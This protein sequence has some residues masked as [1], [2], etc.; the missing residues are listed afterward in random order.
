MTDAEKHLWKHIRKLQLGSFRFVRQFSIGNF[1]LDFYCPKKRLAIEIDGGQHN[2]QKKKLYDRKKDKIL[3]E[4][5]IK[6]LR[7]WNNDVLNKTESVLEKILLT[8]QK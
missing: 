2:E 5:N 4:Q 7:F 1:I 6:V 8:L 3:K